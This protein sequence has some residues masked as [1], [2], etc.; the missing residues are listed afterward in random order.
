[1]VEALLSEEGQRRHVDRALR[2]R[3]ARRRGYSVL[4]RT[5]YGLTSDPVMLMAFHLAV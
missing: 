5:R 3:L 1:M 2:S 4:I